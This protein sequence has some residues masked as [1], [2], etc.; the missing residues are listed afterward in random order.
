MKTLLGMF[1]SLIVSSIV[2]V[3]SVSLGIWLADMVD[4]AYPAFRIQRGNFASKVGRSA[5]SVEDRLR[6][7][8]KTQAN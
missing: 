2:M 4:N 8:F 1:V 3:V 5:A 7:V 6:D